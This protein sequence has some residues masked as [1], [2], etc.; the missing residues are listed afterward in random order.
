MLF[1]T[2]SAEDVLARK[3]Q[4]VVLDLFKTYRANF[5]GCIF[6]PFRTVIHF[7]V[8]IAELSV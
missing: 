4:R 7:P 2:L 8:S 6:L 5:C 1:H 3:L